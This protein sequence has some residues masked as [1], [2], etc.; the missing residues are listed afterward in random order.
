MYLF[1]AVND[2][3][4]CWQYL[5]VPAD[6]FLLTSTPF[7][8]ILGQFLGKIVLILRGLNDH[9][10]LPRQLASR[11]IIIF[12]SSYGPPLVPDIGTLFLRECE[13]SLWIYY[14]L[15]EVDVLIRCKPIGS[16]L[17]IQIQCYVIHVAHVITVWL[18][19][20]YLF[21]LV[22]PRKLFELLHIQ[23]KELTLGLLGQLIILQ[24][25]RRHRKVDDQLIHG[26]EQVL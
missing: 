24:V 13:T 4:R 15:V 21:Y 6:F 9:C 18:L 12:R 23:R 1:Y 3:P 17:A 26:F 8:A 25:A 16:T 2:L 10:F 11:P 5:I 20:F 22:R 7:Y 19:G 14:E